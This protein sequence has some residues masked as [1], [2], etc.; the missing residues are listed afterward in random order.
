MDNRKTFKIYINMRI[1]TCTNFPI[2]SY[3][4]QSYISKSTMSANGMHC[5]IKAVP[6]LAQK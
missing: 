4:P 3:I 5:P 1:V 2:F 6:K